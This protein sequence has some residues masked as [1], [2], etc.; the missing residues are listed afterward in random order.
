MNSI[1]SSEYSWKLNLVG[2]ED[3][4][5]SEVLYSIL[6]LKHEQKYNMNYISVS[7]LSICVEAPLIVVLL[8]NHAGLY[9]IHH[10]S[11]YTIVSRCSFSSS[12]V[13]LCVLFW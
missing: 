10:N 6:L 2:L 1:L 3:V 12:R 4:K 13:Y 7:L 9:T 5:I 8:L 11:V